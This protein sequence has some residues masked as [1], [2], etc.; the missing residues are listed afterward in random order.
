MLKTFNCG[1]GMVVIVARDEVAN[2][3]NLLEET[4]EIVTVIGEVRH[5]PHGAI[6]E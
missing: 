6:V 1:I 2:T 5:G 3:Q 4:G